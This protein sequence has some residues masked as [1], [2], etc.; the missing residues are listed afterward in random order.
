M[1]RTLTAV[2]DTP[3]PQSAITSGH[4]ETCTGGGPG[5]G[6]NL[7]RDTGFPVSVPFLSHYRKTLGLRDT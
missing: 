6:S 5:I 3:L 1:S 2:A 4:T 7:G